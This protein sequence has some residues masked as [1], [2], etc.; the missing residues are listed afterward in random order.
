MQLDGMSDEKYFATVRESNDDQRPLK[1]S[2]RYHL[3]DFEIV[4]GE[5]W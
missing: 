1:V 3:E 2:S 4:E 5:A